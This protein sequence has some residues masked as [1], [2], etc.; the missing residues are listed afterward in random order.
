LRGLAE[1]D[2]RGL[3]TAEPA[4]SGTRKGAWRGAEEEAVEGRGG[5][6]LR[7]FAAADDGEEPAALWGREADEALRSAS[8]KKKEVAIRAAAGGSGGGGGGAAGGRG[9]GWLWWL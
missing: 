5:S 6:R 7:R 1:G 8:E 4:P 3:F 9:R 2:W